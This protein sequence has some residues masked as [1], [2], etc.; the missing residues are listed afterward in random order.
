[1]QVTRGDR[2]TRSLLATRAPRAQ[3]VSLMTSAP[4]SA[5]SVPPRRFVPLTVVTRG[6]VVESVHEGAVA[7]VDRDGQVLYAAGDPLSA[8]S[9]AAR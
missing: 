2:R 4:G 5:R 8:P 1:M 6:G 7:V 9:R 3:L